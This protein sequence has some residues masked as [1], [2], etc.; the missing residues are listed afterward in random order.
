MDN[1]SINPLGLFNDGYCFH[2]SI[3][4]DS[5]ISFSELNFLF[6]VIDDDVCQL[7]ISNRDEPLIEA[8]IT[9]KDNKIYYTQNDENH[10]IGNSD[11]LEQFISDLSFTDGIEYKSVHCITR[12]EKPLK[13]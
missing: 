1:L 9:K 5:E 2:I 6:D 3:G 8:E 11:D 4:R 12:V 13:M 10:F 7:S